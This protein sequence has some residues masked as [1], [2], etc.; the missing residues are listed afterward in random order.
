MSRRD[1]LA[2]LAMQGIV[3][4]PQMILGF[5]DTA[6]REGLTVFEVVAHRAYGIA[7]AMI[8]HGGAD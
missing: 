7:D 2:G 3:G 5:N 6:E 1:W 8:A 4:D